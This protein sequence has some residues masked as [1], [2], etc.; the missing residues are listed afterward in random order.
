MVVFDAYDLCHTV[1]KACREKRCHFAST[2]KSNR[3]LCKAGW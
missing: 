3:S 2:P 1:V